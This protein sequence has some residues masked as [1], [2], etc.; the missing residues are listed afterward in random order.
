MGYIATALADYKVLRLI[1]VRISLQARPAQRSD[2]VIRGERWP[3]AAHES[4]H[5][6]CSSLDE[7]RGDVIMARDTGVDP[8]DRWACWDKR[9]QLGHKS[10]I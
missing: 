10:P 7:G 9:E 6:G 2:W 3:V 4:P 1:T 8:S 5:L